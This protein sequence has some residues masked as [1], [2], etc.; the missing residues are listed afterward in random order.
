MK[1]IT[2][3]PTFFIYFAEPFSYTGYGYKYG[4]I[5]SVNATY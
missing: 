4:I 1:H 2:S 5:V 3:P